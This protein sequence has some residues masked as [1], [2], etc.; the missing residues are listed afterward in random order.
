M[1]REYDGPLDVP[2]EWLKH[3]QLPPEFRPPVERERLPPEFEEP[4]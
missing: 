2:V 3:D 1:E 4:Q